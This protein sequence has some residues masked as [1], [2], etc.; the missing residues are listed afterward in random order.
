MLAAASAVV[1]TSEWTRDLLLD[2]YA[3]P[4]EAV[5]VARPGSTEAPLVARH[6]GRR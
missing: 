5:H 2:A 1:T 3:L 6:A 4:P